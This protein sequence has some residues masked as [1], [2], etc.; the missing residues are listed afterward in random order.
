MSNLWKRRQLLLTSVAGAAAASPLGMVGKASAQQSGKLTYWGGLIFSDAA[1]Q[2]LVDTINQWGQDNGVETEVVM[3]NQNETIQKV[4]AAVESGSMPDA[5]DL[6]VNLLQLLARQDVFLTI[7]DIYDRVGE[8]QGGWFEAVARATDTTDVAGGRTGLPYGVTGNMLLRRKDVLDPAGFTEPPRT[9]T[10]LVEQAAAV[11][12]PPLFGLGL[13]L[14]NVGDANVQVSVM[15]AYGGRIADDTGKTVTIKSDATRR[16]LEWV[17][18]AWDKGLFPPGNTTWDGGGDNQAYLSGQAAFV[19]NTGSI[20]IASSKDD[21]ELF[22]ATGFSSLP[23]GPEGFVSPIQ[24]NLR[25]IPATSQ[26]PEAA[27]ALL[28]HLSQPEF[29]NA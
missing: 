14:S 10:A 8:K 18:D 3:I 9:W 22:E 7:D 6:S 27:R 13:A 19:A 2:L 26:N 20:G 4:S 21:P 1:N 24:P 17:K 29:M 12:K 25:A 16:Y 23:A 11:Q 28:E 15:H 5:L